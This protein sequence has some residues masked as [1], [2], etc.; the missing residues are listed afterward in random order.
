MLSRCF[1]HFV[2]TTRGW[3]KLDIIHEILM[4]HMKTNSIELH[5]ILTSQMKK[6]QVIFFNLMTEEKEVRELLMPSL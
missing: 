5:Q 3:S 4:S 6:N 2:M 1:P